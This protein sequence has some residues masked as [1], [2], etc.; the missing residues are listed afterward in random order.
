MVGA[1]GVIF[2]PDNQIGKQYFWDLSIVSNNQNEFLALSQG[3]EIAIENKFF[4]ILAF[5]N[6]IIVILQVWKTRKPTP[7]LQRI[8]LQI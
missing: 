8:A 6:S 7:I 2:C 1:G 3:L 5:G 4:K